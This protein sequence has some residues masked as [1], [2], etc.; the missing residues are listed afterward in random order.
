[1]WD[2]F[3]DHKG[4]IRFI[5]DTFSPESMFVLANRLYGATQC[6]SMCVVSRSIQLTTGQFSKVITGEVGMHI[7]CKAA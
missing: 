2:D 3:H 6:P 4:G 5:T 1:M 7:V